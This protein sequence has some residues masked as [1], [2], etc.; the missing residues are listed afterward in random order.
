MNPVLTEH[1]LCVEAGLQVISA[2]STHILAQQVGNPAR[3]DIRHKAFP[4]RAF[5]ITARPSIVRIVDDVFIASLLCVSFKITFLIQN[6]VR[7]SRCV[8]IAGQ[9]LIERGDFS[10]VCLVAMVRRSFQTDGSL[11]AHSV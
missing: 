2:D 7:V 5:K 11:V 8:I 3:L 9:A 1:H 4:S 6:G 10:S